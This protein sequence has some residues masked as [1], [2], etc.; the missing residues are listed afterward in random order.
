MRHR[1]ETKARISATLK[2]RRPAG[3]FILKVCPSCGLQMN[4]PNLG[5]HLPACMG[6]AESGLFPDLSVK[7]VKDL[8]RKLRPYGLTATEYAALWARQGGVCN[9]CG[10]DS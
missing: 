8:R 9:I 10:G 2:G 3:F 4:A 5:R 7:E 1:Q 6:K